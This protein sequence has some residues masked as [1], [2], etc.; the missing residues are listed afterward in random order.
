MCVS[1]IRFVCMYVCARVCMHLSHECINL[2][3]AFF[4]HVCIYLSIAVIHVCMYVSIY[5]FYL[6]TVH[7]ADTV[8][9]LTCKFSL[10]RVI[11]RTSY[12]PTPPNTS[13]LFVSVMLLKQR[14]HA[15]THL[16]Q[17]VRDDMA[18]MQ[19]LLTMH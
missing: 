8:L 14:S 3:I 7:S 18:A 6:S 16:H 1:A 12:A 11:E 17:T 2:S 13:F 15:P 5:R 9:V 10:D 4:S 19:T